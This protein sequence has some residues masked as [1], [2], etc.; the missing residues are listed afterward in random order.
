MIINL[1]EC[2]EDLV[3]A[4]L[5]AITEHLQ[6][7]THEGPGGILGGDNGYGVNYETDI[8]MMH[9]FCWCE[10]PDCA[11]CLECECPEEAEVY[12]V[13][14]QRV[15]YEEYC[16]EYERTGNTVRDFHTDPDLECAQCVKRRTVGFAPNFLYKPTGATVHWYKYIGRSMEIDGSL[17][18]DFHIRSI[19]SVGSGL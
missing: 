10:R 16:N 3:S 15:S 18:L 14:G 2:S 12:T 7:V 5:R 1:P 13:R 9:R 17:P 8:F 6:Q 11:W 4:G 19:E